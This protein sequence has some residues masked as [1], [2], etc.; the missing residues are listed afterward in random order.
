MNKDIRKAVLAMAVMTGCASEG[1]YPGGHGGGEE[2]EQPVVEGSYALESSLVLPDDYLAG[3][4]PLL[5]QFLSMTDDPDDPATW[6]LDRAEDQLGW[7]EAAAL[8]TARETLGLDAIVN[9]LILAHSPDLVADLV[10]LGSDSAELAGGLEVSSR[11]V[12][13]ETAGG[14]LVADHEVTGFALA[15]DGQVAAVEGVALPAPARVAVRQENGV[16]VIDRH[17]F[18]IEQGAILRYG[19]EEVAL[20]RVAPNASSLSGWLAY[21]IDC[22][23]IGARIEDLVEVGSPEDYEDACAAVVDRAVDEVVGDAF[24]MRAE[25]AMSG[26]ADLGDDDGDGLID[27]LAGTWQAAMTVD[28]ASLSMPAGRFEGTRE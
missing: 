22:T 13:H 4:A 20:P 28:G 14:A 11:L 25:V 23:G 8:A 2:E 1:R 10:Q 27:V 26:R 7:L 5:D 6:I 24:E 19:M 12:V 3:P 9:Q 18:V 17:A 16:L 21:E 15:L